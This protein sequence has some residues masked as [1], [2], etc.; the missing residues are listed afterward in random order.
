VATFQRPSLPITRFLLSKFSDPTRRQLEA[1][2]SSFPELGKACEAL[3]EEL[4]RVIQSGSIYELKLFAGVRLSVETEAMRK[5]DPQGERLTRL[6]RL[7]LEDAYPFN[8]LKRPRRTEPLREWPLSEVVHYVT[9]DAYRASRASN[10]ICVLEIPWHDDEEEVVESF[11]LWLRE[12]RGG[13]PGKTGAGRKR[14]WRWWFTNL[15]IHRLSAAGFDRNEVLKK[16]G[17]SQCVELQ[18]RRPIHQAGS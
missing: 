6:N 14:E 4:N 5:G 9:S 1:C 18:P 10:D 8:L 16:G 3:V 12:H 15:G 7:L 13:C 11:H 17:G 2:G